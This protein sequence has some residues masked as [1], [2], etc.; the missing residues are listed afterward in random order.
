VA[1]ARA[2]AAAAA[3]AGGG[4]GITRGELNARA[5]GYLPLGRRSGTNTKRHYTSYHRPWEGGARRSRKTRRGR[6]RKSSGGRSSKTRR[7][8]R[9]GSRSNRRN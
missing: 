3:A 7:N 5:N 4:G 6:S 9:R 2:S 1:A 8:R